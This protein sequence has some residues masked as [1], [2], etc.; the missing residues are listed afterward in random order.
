MDISIE[1]IDIKGRAVIIVDIVFVIL[2]EII[3]KHRYMQ[4]Y[5]F[6]PKK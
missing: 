3:A 5:M 4:T 2:F 1:L 6:K